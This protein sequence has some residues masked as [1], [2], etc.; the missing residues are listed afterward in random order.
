MTGCI[1]HAWN[2]PISTSGIKSDGNI[3]FLNPDF[4]QDVK[5]SAIRVH[6]RQI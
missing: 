3:V 1:V 5:I 6:L 2:G 4:L